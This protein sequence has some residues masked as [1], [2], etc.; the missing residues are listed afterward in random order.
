MGRGRSGSTPRQTV[1]ALL[2]VALVSGAVGTWWMV[3]SVGRVQDSGLVA[4]APLATGAPD[5]VREAPALERDLV[6]TLTID[7]RLRAVPAAVV[8]AAWNPRAAP[9]AAA[10]ELGQRTR[11]AL[12]VLAQLWPAGGD[13][14][15]L[16]ARLLD[17]SRNRVVALVEA[18]ELR[19]RLSV[20]GG[21]VGARLLAR[22]AQ[23]S[24]SPR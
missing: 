16:V 12:V 21:E 7:K 14:V 24:S 1:A 10:L 15:R 22:W 17:V 8:E 2:A 19:S 5:L 3:R 13:S 23:S 18:T 11:A 6:T 9:A 4:V 20:L